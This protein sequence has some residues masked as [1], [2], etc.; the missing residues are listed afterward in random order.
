VLLDRYFIIQVNEDI[1][2]IAHFLTSRNGLIG[3]E[4]GSAIFI[5]F[6]NCKIFNHS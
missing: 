2:L 5:S 6:I 4:D 3:G 1:L